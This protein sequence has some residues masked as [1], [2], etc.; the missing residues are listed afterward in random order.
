MSTAITAGDVRSAKVALDSMRSSLVTWVTLR[1]KNDRVAAGVIRTNKP[2]AYAREVISQ[3]RD[4]DHEARLAKQLYILLTESFPEAAADVPMPDVSVDSDAAVKLAKIAITGRIPSRSSGPSAVGAINWTSWP[5]LIVGGLLLAYTTTVKTVADVA[6]EK[7]RIACVESGG[8]TDYGFW[9]KA[10]GIV[11][12][13]YVA[14]QLGLG[15]T[16]K[17]FLK[18]TK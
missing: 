13:G 12:I 14:W 18:G 2:I 3:N 5:V 16:V 4:M 17:K 6:I 9:L 15:D 8:C 10:G 11:A 1:Q 7:E